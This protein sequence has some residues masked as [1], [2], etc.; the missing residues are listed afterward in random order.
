MFIKDLPFVFR[1]WFSPLVFD[2]PESLF[3]LLFSTPSFPHESFS[4]V[5]FPSERETR[6][7][8]A[9]PCHP[10]LVWL[11]AQCFPAQLPGRISLPLYTAAKHFRGGAF[12]TC[13]PR[14]LRHRVP[15]AVPQVLPPSPEAPYLREQTQQMFSTMVSG[16]RFGDRIFTKVF[17]KS[18]LDEFN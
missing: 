5:A 9:K 16:F 15:P 10:W 6:L 11:M 2:D 8:L 4:V 17:F 1:T 13:D 18:L 14:S 3:S 7:G 12:M